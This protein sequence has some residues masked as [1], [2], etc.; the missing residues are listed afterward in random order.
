MLMI[1]HSQLLDI[2]NTCGYIKKMII[3]CGREE[4]VLRPIQHEALLLLKYGG[5]STGCSTSSYERM[6]MI[7]RCMICVS[8]FKTADARSDDPAMKRE[9][10]GPASEFCRIRFVN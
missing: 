2:D 3:I 6:I 5:H 9:T 10:V 7:R 8:G 4:E 1:L